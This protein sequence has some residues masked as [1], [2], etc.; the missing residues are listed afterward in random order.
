MHLHYSLIPELDWTIAFAR[1]DSQVFAKADALRNAMFVAFVAM[2]I[3]SALYVLV[4]V[5]GDQNANA[6]TA[7]DSEVCKILME[8]GDDRRQI[9]DALGYLCQFVKGRTVLFFDTDGDEYVYNDPKQSKLSLSEKDKLL[10]MTQLLR[11]ADDFQQVDE[12]AVGVMRL[13]LDKLLKKENPAIYALLD[14]H[15][16]QE[17]SFGATITQASYTVI[18]AVVDAK[19]GN[20]A[21]ALAESVAPCFSL[22]LYNRNRYNKTQKAATTDA[23]TG[24]W[25]RVAYKQ[26]LLELENKKV[27]DFACVYVDVNELHLRNNLYGHAAGD[28]MLITIANTLKEVFFGHKVY[29]MGGDEFV[30]TC[31]DTEYERMKQNIALLQERLEFYDYH[32]SVGMSYRSTNTNT[33]EMVKEAEERMYREKALFY[34]KKEQ[35]DVQ[36][37]EEYIHLLTGI[38]E[39]DKFL[40]VASKNYQGIFRV[41]LNTDHVKRILM[42]KNL[43]YGEDEVDFAKLFTQYIAQDVAPEYR[44]AITTFTNYDALKQQLLEGHSPKLSYRKTNGDSVA[45]S[46]YMLDA[47]ETDS[48][49]TLWVFELEPKL[50]K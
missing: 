21:T 9:L 20:A 1:Y 27:R 30:V 11:Y 47:A 3:F 4:L 41:S 22:A 34:Q 35:N 7:C 50:D 36:T 19:K 29:R 17:V 46:V 10:A 39:I 25:N 26:D 40:S 23:L 8:S 2:T 44:R 13:R 24:T 45:L 33:E 18:L 42:T 28:E 5:I 31:R 6:I 43:H 14:K 32:V 16:I 37:N 48:F 15:G 49:D 12:T 38:P